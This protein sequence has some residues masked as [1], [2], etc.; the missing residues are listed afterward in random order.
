MAPSTLGYMPLS[1]T[2]PTAP[3]LP[4][5]IPLSLSHTPMSFNKSMPMSLS[6]APLSLGHSPL[7]IGHSIPFSLGHTHVAMTTQIPTASHIHT[8]TDTTRQQNNT[9]HTPSWLSHTHNGNG[10]PSTQVRNAFSPF[11]SII[12][13]ISL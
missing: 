3:H 11:L 5:A 6:Q 12:V 2:T 8:R 4:S 13:L 1:V 10:H 9:Y 7:S